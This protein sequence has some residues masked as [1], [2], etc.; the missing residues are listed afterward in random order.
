MRNFVLSE[1]ASSIAGEASGD[2]LDDAFGDGGSAT[3]VIAITLAAEEYET[4]TVVLL[5]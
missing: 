4:H 1:A 3:A 5:E 2:V